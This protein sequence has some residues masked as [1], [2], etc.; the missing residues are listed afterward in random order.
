MKKG[1]SS[2]PLEKHLQYWLNH[3][4]PVFVLLVKLDTMTVYWQEI[5][6]KS[7]APAL[8][9]VS[10]LRSPRPTSSNGFQPVAGCGREVRVDCS[11]RLRGQS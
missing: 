2:G 8:G 10:T 3:S 11:G 4:L 6:E 9:A 5:T 7:C 1:G